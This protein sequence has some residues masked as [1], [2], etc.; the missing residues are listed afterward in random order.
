VNKHSLFESSL[1]RVLEY[2]HPPNDDTWVAPQAITSDVP[3]VVFPRTPV[4]VRIPHAQ[5]Y[6]TTPNHALFFNPGTVYSR[7]PVGPGGDE[8]LEFQLGRAAMEALEAETPAVRNG[9]LLVRDAAVPGSAHILQYLLGRHLKEGAGDP[10]LVEETALH[11]VRVLLKPSPQSYGQ[12]AATRMQHRELAEA[13]KRLLA[14]DLGSHLSL[15]DIARE[16][17]CS[18]FHLERLFR[19]ETGFTLHAYRT[20]LRLRAALERLPTAGGRLARLACELGFVSH[21]HFTTAFVRTFG[22]PPSAVTDPVRA[23]RHLET[24][25]LVLAA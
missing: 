4:E 19:R 12:R 1:V 3:I 17:T 7:H 11:I 18:P 5:P 16:L 20:Q 8:Y 15:A 25:T 10:R 6:L 24:S 13:A 21:S 22:L 9:R 2:V 23:R 14:A